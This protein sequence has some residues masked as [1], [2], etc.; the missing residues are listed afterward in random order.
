[1]HTRP[2]GVINSFLTFPLGL[3]ASEPGCSEQQIW[4]KV[5]P[6]CFHHGGK[7]CNK[8]ITEHDNTIADSSKM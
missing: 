2:W 5:S 3:L 7:L 1:M 6:G 4:G 8:V